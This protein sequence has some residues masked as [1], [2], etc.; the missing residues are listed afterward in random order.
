[1]RRI[2]LSPFLSS[3]LASSALANDST[4]ELTTGGLVLTRS[5]DIEM[6]SEDLSISEREIVVHYKF[7]NR[8][9]ADVTVTV[10]FPLP[11]IVWGGIDQFP[12]DDR[13]G[14]ARQSRQ[15]LRDRCEEDFADTIRSATF[16]I[17]ADA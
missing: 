13:Q 7:F 9:A 6:S 17:H 10:A 12:F 3:V 15:L 2:L 1:M 4:A 8:A 14:R 16:A 11:D 5:A